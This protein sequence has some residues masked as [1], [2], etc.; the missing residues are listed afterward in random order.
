MEVANPV[1]VTGRA[2][3]F[4]N[5]VTLRVRDAKGV[6]I[7][8]TFTTATGEIG[9]HNPFRGSVWLTRDPGP[10]I[11]VEAL[12]YS[13]KDGSEQSL[14]SVRKP[15]AV[16]RVDVQLFLPNQDCTGVVAHRRR[17][18]KSISMA[19]LLVEMLLAERAPF[20]KD[21]ALQSINLR[22]GTVTVDFNERL[23]NVGGA[24]AAQMIRESVTRTLLTLPSVKKV[25]ITAAGSES[26]AL[27]P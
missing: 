16:E 14:V 15:F 19:R 7:T 1:V 12:E 26:L 23:R 11:T 13:A 2:R 25:V 10:A 4:E 17:V 27:Q 3:T 24:C 21:A 5:H 6:L 22:N 18:P 20:P 8:E 9:H